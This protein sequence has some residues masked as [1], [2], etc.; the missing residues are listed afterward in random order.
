VNFLGEATIL[1]A[2]QLVLFARQYPFSF[3]I[4][5]E[6]ISGQ[7]RCC[8]DKPPTLPPELA[9]ADIFLF[10]TM[11]TAVKGKT[12]QDAED[13]KKTETAELNA[14]PLEAFADF[15]KTF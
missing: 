10:P 7:T 6:K 8:G 5:S 1:S 12:F 4:G 3:R 9:P 14:V 15:S 2:G 13:I 11:K